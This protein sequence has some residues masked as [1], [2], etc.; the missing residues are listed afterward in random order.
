M[1][2]RRPRW[3]RRRTASCLLA[4][5]TCSPQRIPPNQAQGA[6]PRSHR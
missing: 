5:T 2:D 6:S 4:L 1:D 3:R